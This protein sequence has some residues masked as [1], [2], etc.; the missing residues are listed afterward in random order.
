LTRIHT[1]S[2]RAFRP[3][4]GTP[5]VTSLGLPR[6]RPEAQDWPRCWLITGQDEAR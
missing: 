6:W 4:M 5:V 3:D 2:Y 1:S